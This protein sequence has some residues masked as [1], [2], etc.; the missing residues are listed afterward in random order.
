MNKTKFSFS[1]RFCWPLRLNQPI[2]S[3]EEI[4]TNTAVNRSVS[5]WTKHVLMLC[6]GGSGLNQVGVCP[7]CSVFFLTQKNPQ[8]QWCS[9]PPPGLLLPEGW[10]LM[11]RKISLMDNQHI[12]ARLDTQHHSHLLSPA[13]RPPKVIYV[14]PFLH[15][16]FPLVGI[17]GPNGELFRVWVYSEVETVHLIYWLSALLTFIS[18][19]V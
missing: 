10:Q 5:P 11:K 1:R 19:W 18:S 12:A 17:S 7:T 16:P 13:C 2:T 15:I 4:I 6:S 9:A 14:S 8:K 3:L